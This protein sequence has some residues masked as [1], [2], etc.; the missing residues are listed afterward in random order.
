MGKFVGG[1]ECPVLLTDAP[2][3][4]GADFEGQGV[5]RVLVRFD[6]YGC[7]LALRRLDV[8]NHRAV[9]KRAGHRYQV[10]VFVVVYQLAPCDDV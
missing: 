3:T 5:A 10:P 2:I 6:I 1:D 8:H 9:V 4:T 7:G